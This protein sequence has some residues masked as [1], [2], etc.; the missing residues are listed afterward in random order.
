MNYFLLGVVTASP[1]RR[2]FCVICVVHDQHWSHKCINVMFLLLSDSGDSQS[3]ANESPV[4]NHKDQLGIKSINYIKN[5][6]RIA[7]FFLLI[8]DPFGYVVIW[9]AMPIYSWCLYPGNPIFRRMSVF[10]L[11]MLA[12]KIH[13]NSVIVLIVTVK[14]VLLKIPGVQV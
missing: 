10:Y 4:R 2:Q 7:T 3:W 1:L 11:L 6:I 5:G 13:I 12:K 14:Q 8:H 9:S